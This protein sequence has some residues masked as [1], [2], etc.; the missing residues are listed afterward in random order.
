MIEVA[1]KDFGWNNI[2][3]VVIE[4][5]KHLLPSSGGAIE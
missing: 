1:E 5:P 4:S 2:K 3:R